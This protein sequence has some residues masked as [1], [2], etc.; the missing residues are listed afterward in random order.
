MF[1]LQYYGPPL[2][3]YNGNHVEGSEPVTVKAFALQYS[4]TLY[5]WL[6]NGQSRKYSWTPLLVATM[7]NHVK[8]VNLLLWSCFKSALRC[9]SGAE[10]RSVTLETAPALTLYIHIITLSERLW[11]YQLWP[12]TC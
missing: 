4:W 2:V 9:W 7:G 1:A 8:V 6:H 5:W 12:T 3:A 11:S 10:Q